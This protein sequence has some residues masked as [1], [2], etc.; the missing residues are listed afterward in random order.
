MSAP[1]SRVGHGG[2]GQQL[3]ASR[4]CRPSP[5]PSCSTPQWPWSVYSHR[6][7]SVMT[8][9]SGAASL[10]AATVA[11]HDPAR[12]PRRRARRAR[13][14]RSGSRT[15]APRRRRAP[16]RR[17]SAAAG[18]AT[19]GSGRA[20]S[21]SG[22]ARRA[23]R[24]EERQ[25]E[26][27]A[28]SAGSRAPSGGWRRREPQPAH[29]H[30]RE[31]GGGRRGGDGSPPSPAG[32]YSP[33]PPWR[34]LADCPGGRPTC[35]RR[36]R[37]PRRRPVAGRP[38]RGGLAGAR[39]RA[40]ATR[41]STR[42]A[43]RTPRWP[44]RGA[45]RE[46]TRS[47]PRP[48]PRAERDLGGLDLVVNA[49]TSVP[50]DHSFGGGPVADAP[51]D[52]LERWMAGYLPAAWAILRGGGAALARRGA[53]TLVQVS[54]GSAR[55]GMPGRGPWGRGAVRGPGADPVAGAGA[56][57]GRRPRGAAGGRRRSSAPSATR[58]RAARPRSRWPPEDVARAR[59]PTSR[60]SPRGAGP[61]SS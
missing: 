48:W 18:R 55:R 31:S 26:T 29:P 58:W 49:T 1:A 2:A 24:D 50:R 44:W 22:R 57:A 37:R 8:T 16:A 5:S 39:G 61:T 33:V 42:C 21:R 17:A 52:R 40:Q 20:S 19:G 59:S 27:V 10:I 12:R 4:R 54:G 3:A 38:P 45:T 6:Q 60:A 25:D 34:P 14:S 56:A 7:T 36:V 13:P 43:R 23:P 30:A 35:P 15:A 53:G 11:W 9:S 32:V 51:P 47:L 46:T 28:A 41:P